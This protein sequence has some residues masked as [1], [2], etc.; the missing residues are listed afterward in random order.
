LQTIEITAIVAKSGF[1]SHFTAPSISEVLNRARG[2]Y[3]ELTRKIT[4]IFRYI[5]LSKSHF[6]RKIRANRE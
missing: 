6:L 3:C 4:G 5:H 1:L 2:V